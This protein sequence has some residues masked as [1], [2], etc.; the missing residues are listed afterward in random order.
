MAGFESTGYRT[1][2]GGYPVNVPGTDGKSSTQAQYG[3]HY[4]DPKMVRNLAQTLGGVQQGA[5]SQYLPFLQNPTAS[6]LFQGQLSGLLASLQPSEDLAR[7]NLSDQLRAS[8]NA[9]SSTGAGAIRMGES[10]ILRN[11]QELS[12]KLLG[13]SFDQIVRALM[14]PQ[15]QI[16]QL[17]NA[18]KLNYGTGQSAGAFSGG[19]SGWENIPQS[20]GL[21][22][23][24]AGDQLPTTMSPLQQQMASGISSPTGPSIG[25]QNFIRQLQNAMQ[26][27]TPLGERQGGTDGPG[28]GASFSGVDAAKM[29]QTLGLSQPGIYSQM[30]DEMG[31]PVSSNEVAS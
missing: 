25:D 9:A 13:Q 30:Y 26:G 22:T 11:R 27:L 2:M 3:S 21:Q 6:P 5:A 24:M 16:P 28:I 7:R 29:A 23:P 12:S 14:A 17:I 15:Q 18:L 31:N 20:L 8:G 1:T 4:L 10:D 19:S